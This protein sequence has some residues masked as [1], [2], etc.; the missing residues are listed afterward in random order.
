MNVV[1]LGTDA[2]L[3][4]P[5]TKF[6]L[7]PVTWTYIPTCKPCAEAVV[8]VAISLDDDILEIVPSVEEVSWTNAVTETLAVPVLAASNSINI[9]FTPLEP[10]F[11]V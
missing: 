11:A 9:E 4:I 2:T 8:T 3:Y 10:L 1:P 5:F 6:V 7:E